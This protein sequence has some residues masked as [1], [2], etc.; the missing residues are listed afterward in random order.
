MPLLLF[1]ELPRR[2]IL[3]NRGLLYTCTW[4]LPEACAVTIIRGRRPGAHITRPDFVQWGKSAC[5]YR[6]LAASC[7]LYSRT[8]EKG[9]GWL[10]TGAEGAGRYSSMIDVGSSV[11]VRPSQKGWWFG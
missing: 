8:A 3:G 7:L 5:A 1:I 10:L 6:T 9:R 2:G 4:H 11:R